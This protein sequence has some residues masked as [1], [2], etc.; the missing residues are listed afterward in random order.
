MIRAVVM[1]AALAILFLSSSGIGW[2]QMPPVR[3]VPWDL[4]SRD[5]VAV[6]DRHVLR[7]S[8]DRFRALAENTDRVHLSIAFSSRGTRS[9]TVAVPR[10]WG[11]QKAVDC[12]TDAAKLLGWKMRDRFAAD[13]GASILANVTSSHRDLASWDEVIPWPDLVKNLRDAG[14]ERVELRVRTS[15]LPLTT[16]GR[17]MYD[18][19]D[20]GNA[21]MEIRVLTCATV[22]PPPAMK[23][24]IGFTPG[25]VRSRVR[26]GLLTLFAGIAILLM[27]YRWADRAAR[28]GATA[29][30]HLGMLR[31]ASIIASLVWLSLVILS[32]MGFL[33]TLTNAS[34]P[35]ALA[36]R[37]TLLMGPPVLFYGVASSLRRRVHHV[38]SAVIPQQPAIAARYGVALFG[39][40]TVT[41]FVILL[42]THPSQTPVHALDQAY[43]WLIPVAVVL[44]VIT[45]LFIRSI[46]GRP[47]T[48]TSGDLFDRCRELGDRAGVS[49]AN[50]QIINGKLARANGLTTAGGTI[51]VTRLALLHMTK[52]EID[53]LLAH[54]L[55]HLKLRH[56]EQRIRMLL[57]I[58]FPIGAGAAFATITGHPVLAAAAIVFGPCVLLLRTP[59]MRK[60]EFQADYAGAELLGSPR[61]MIQ[62]HASLARINRSSIRV[63]SLT[64]S[65][66]T[67]PS[68]LRRMR[69]LAARYGI[70]PDEV[71]RII[72]QYGPESGIAV[73]PL[74]PGV[75]YEIPGAGLTPQ[76]I[77]FQI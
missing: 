61:A 5:A 48:V 46:R 3:R 64:E 29:K 75:G 10:A 30:L 54:E 2:A 20:A 45:W 62:L 36:L 49:V 34:R 37:F 68:L 70:P 67:H 51:M 16:S 12:A 50:L 66:S 15:G 26:A 32:G 55:A 60:Q 71:D 31:A 65:I 21:A 23:I 33:V 63:R 76:P 18:W 19:Y 43:I 11:E 28:S 41:A 74:A 39:L 7:N 58:V 14:A 22:S 56:V 69:V 35:V 59:A 17:E 40:S 57:A 9:I 42:T 38:G 53:A 8:G 13:T 25:F 6:V 27:I 1:T 52:P 72:A 77:A 4:A 73:E 44:N 47:L 24:T